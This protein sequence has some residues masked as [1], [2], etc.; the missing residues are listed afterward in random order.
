MKEAQFIKKVGQNIKS[1]RERQNLTQ[2]DLAFKCD[3]DKTSINRLEAGRTNPT[4]KTLLKI[5]DAL[6]VKI[7]DLFNF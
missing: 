3:F 7:S 2:V 6:E 5:A 4:I 1:I